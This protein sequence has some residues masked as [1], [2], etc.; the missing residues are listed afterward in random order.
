MILQEEKDTGNG[1]RG[2]HC[3]GTESLTVTSDDIC[4]V[5]P[6]ATPPL[7]KNLN[8]I[9]AGIFLYATSAYMVSP[10]KSIISTL[11]AAGLREFLKNYV[12]HSIRQIVYIF[13]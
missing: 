3:S 11:M 12:P 4:N 10:L 5:L 7:F 9:Q 6:A 13:I 2:P 1:W 8:Q